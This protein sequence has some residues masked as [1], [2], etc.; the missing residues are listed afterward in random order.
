M[1]NQILYHESNADYH[2][3]PAVSKSNLD[4]YRTRP[5]KYKLT[6]I[7][8]T[9]HRKPPS[10]AMLFGQ[11]SHSVILDDPAEAAKL[12]AFPA[13][14]MRRGKSWNAFCDMQQDI[15]EGVTCLPDP[16]WMLRANKCMNSIMRHPVAASLC[17]FDHYSKAKPPAKET[18][19]RT[20]IIP[21][22]GFPIQ[23]RAD[24][25]NLEKCAVCDEPYFVDLK[26]ISSLDKFA[27]QD[28]E[29]SFQQF[30]YHRQA[31][32]YSAVVNTILGEGT[33]K[34]FFFVVY[35]T[36]EPFGVMVCEPCGNAFDLGYMEVLESL[37]KLSG[38]IKNNDWEDEFAAIRTADLPKW[39]YNKASGE[40]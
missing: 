36:E 1:N 21:K 20:D 23:A 8:K 13:E 19:F 32:F 31:A 4:L 25:I 28:F 5:L 26:S 10:D 7:D 18:T 35:E 6:H 9:L 40:S 12:W 38:S 30:G 16:A 24:I 3:N 39:Y 27:W 34:R 29:H 15:N 22:Y 2:A 11:Y 14:K 37:H 33:I 17:G